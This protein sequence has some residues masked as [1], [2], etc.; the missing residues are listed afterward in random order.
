M[1]AH[2]IVDN[3]YLKIVRMHFDLQSLFNHLKPQS[4]SKYFLPYHVSNVSINCYIK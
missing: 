1:A 4:Y 2:I 3:G